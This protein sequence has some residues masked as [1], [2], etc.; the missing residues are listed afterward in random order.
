[1][2]PGAVRSDSVRTNAM[3][4]G[5][6]GRRVVVALKAVDEAYPLYGAVAL[7][8]PSLTS[9]RRSRTAAWWSSAACS[10]GSASR[11]ATAADR[12][13]RLRDPRG[14]PA[15]ARPHRRLRQ[16][17]PARDDP[18]RPAARA[19]RPSCR[20]RSRATPTAS[21][22]PR[23]AMPRPCW[24]AARPS[25]RRRAGAPAARATS[26][27]ASPASPIGSR[28]YLTLAGL[29]RAVDRRRRRRARDPEL[30]RRQDRDDRHPQVPGRLERPRVPDLPAAGPGAGRRRHPAR[31]RDRPRAP[32]LLSALA[33][34]LLPI[35]VVA[36][37]Y[38]LPLLIAAGCGLL[39]ALSFAIWPLAR[40]REVSPAAM[41][42]ALIAPPGALAAGAGA[43]A[44]RAQRRSGSRCS[45]WPASPTAG[46]G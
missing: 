25:T 24:R 12:R 14:D 8:P 35:Q 45:R 26:S 28:R 46:S 13:R 5:S 23:A 11:S 43:G 37:F 2:P 3:A 17:R 40:T 30:P 32:W 29:D 15:R 10:A 44:A 19:P 21:R 22:C 1:M 27:R 4:E 16:H 31:P 18:A 39:T 6:D 42:R 20:A 34:P 36:G 38:P 9:T 7:D 33:A 41:F